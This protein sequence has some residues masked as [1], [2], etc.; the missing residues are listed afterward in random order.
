MI[1]I[2]I[3]TDGFWLF[4]YVDWDM[5]VILVAVRVLF[6]LDACVNFK[7]IYIVVFIVLN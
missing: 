2:E 7:I 4:I 1:K 6:S 3:A 5:W